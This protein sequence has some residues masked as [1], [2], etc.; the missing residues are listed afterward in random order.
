VT[1]IDDTRL[2]VSTG[3]YHQISII[4]FASKKTEKIINT[5]IGCYGITQNDGSLLLSEVQSSFR[6]CNPFMP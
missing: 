1:C 6:I 4:N 5:S 2:V 3:M